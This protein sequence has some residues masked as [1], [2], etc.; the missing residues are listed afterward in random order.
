MTRDELLEKISKA[1]PAIAATFR[2]PLPPK[3]E[4]VKTEYM[5][6]FEKYGCIIEATDECLQFDLSDKVIN[7][8]HTAAR[9]LGRKIRGLWYEAMSL[10]SREVY[11]GPH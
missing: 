9:N 11:L 2:V 5:H 6:D 4:T 8:L 1:W 3:F 7:E 10:D